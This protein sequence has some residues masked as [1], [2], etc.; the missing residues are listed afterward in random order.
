MWQKSAVIV[1]CLI[2]GI[3]TCVSVEP[4]ACAKMTQFRLSMWICQ[5]VSVFP[6]WRLTTQTII[7]YTYRSLFVQWHEDDFSKVKIMC[8]KGENWK[9]NFI[10]ERQ[11]C[12]VIAFVVSSQLHKLT[13]LPSLQHE[14]PDALITTS[15]LKSRLYIDEDVDH[16]NLFPPAAFA[17]LCDSPD[18][19]RNTSKRLLQYY[20]QSH[21]YHAINSRA[22][23]PIPSKTPFTLTSPLF[24][25][26]QIYSG[27]HMT[28]LH[29]G[30]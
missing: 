30:N 25:P 1:E 9:E 4:T 19:D 26:Q 14:P 16:K 13:K 2:R 11:T 28:N 20:P 7:N 29:E 22:S 21:Q 10:K 15:S 18:D 27:H 5:T 3:D 24:P 17:H 23:S 12:V 8:E 6:C